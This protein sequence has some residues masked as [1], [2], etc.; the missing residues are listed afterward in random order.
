MKIW[1]S[2]QMS[3]ET[4]SAFAISFFS[5]RVRKPLWLSTAGLIALFAAFGFGCTA[6]SASERGRQARFHSLTQDSGAFPCVFL[7]DQETTR[8]ELFSR[9]GSPD[10]QFEGG[11]VVAYW[12]RMT[13]EG[14]ILTTAARD[15]LN[16]VLMVEFTGLA[17]SDVLIRHAF[18]HRSIGEIG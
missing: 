1:R 5:G 3:P 14:R 10:Q 2:S 4:G 6:P 17:D 11:R 12:L 13:P 8:A 18:L 7:S 9:L 16:L 15:G